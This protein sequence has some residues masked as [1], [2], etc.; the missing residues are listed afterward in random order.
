[1]AFAAARMIAKDGKSG[2]KKSLEDGVGKVIEKWNMCWCYMLHKVSP[3]SKDG[4]DGD[5]DGTGLDQ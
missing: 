2:R 3:T 1:M 4:D 5:T